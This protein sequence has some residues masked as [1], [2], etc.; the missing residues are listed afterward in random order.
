MVEIEQE[1]LERLKGIEKEH[2]T[3]KEAHDKLTAEHSTLKDDYITL[4]KKGQQ[5]KVD[6]NVD[7]FD[8]ACKQRYG[9]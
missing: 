2:L 9:K 7:L 1:E 6:N 8:E 4:F 5:G 3:L